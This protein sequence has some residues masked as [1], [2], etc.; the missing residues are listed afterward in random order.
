MRKKYNTIVQIINEV[1]EEINSILN[2]MNKKR[3]FEGITL[4]Y[5]FIENILKW[6]VFVKILWGKANRELSQKEVEKLKS[7]CKN[8]KFY[9]ALN[10]ALSV[11]LIDFE[12]YEKIN[13]IRKERN[14]VIHQFWIYSHRNNFLVL[15]K[16]LEKLAKVANELVEIFNRLT[17]EIGIEEVYEILF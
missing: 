13:S 6:M 16:K 15:R 8:L 17:Q 9:N 3:Y 11:D 14:N 4:L 1:A 10:I 5:S 7:F 2:N 12:L